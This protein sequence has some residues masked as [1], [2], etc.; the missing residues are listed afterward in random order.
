MC[1]AEAVIQLLGSIVF[2][3]HPMAGLR[4]LLCPSQLFRTISHSHMQAIVYPILQQLESS[5][6]ERD[7]K[8]K[9]RCKDIVSRR[10]MEDWK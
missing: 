10:R 1:A 5:L 9:G 3:L 4:L 6:I 8:G 7:L 2:V